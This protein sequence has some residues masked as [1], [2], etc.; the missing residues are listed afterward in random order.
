MQDVH[1][2]AGGEHKLYAFR[3]YLARS[4]TKKAIPKTKT[5]EQE[6]A[7]SDNYNGL[8]DLRA[9]VGAVVIFWVVIIGAI[10]GMLQL[11][12]W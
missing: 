4:K 12:G 1:S 2:R 8:P 7:D 3:D 9:L 6:D 10:K 11:C 5:P